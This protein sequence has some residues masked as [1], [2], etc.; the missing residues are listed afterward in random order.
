MSGACGTKHTRIRT[1][2]CCYA[3]Q[4]KKAA[5][6]CSC[7]CVPC[8]T[9][10]VCLMRSCSRVSVWDIFL[11]AFMS[12]LGRC[13]VFISCFLECSRGCMV[14]EPAVFL[15]LCLRVALASEYRRAYTSGLCLCGGL[16]Y[17]R[18]R[19]PPHWPAGNEREALF[20]R[21]AN[22]S[23]ACRRGGEDVQGSLNFF[24]RGQNRDMCLV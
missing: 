21:P 17:V 10:C 5:I 14:T 7:V 4:S 24:R 1:G 23:T 8:C 9:A 11:R 6:V 15:L 12:I 20:S 16:T 22:H 19:S 13:D 2:L 18:G 3:S